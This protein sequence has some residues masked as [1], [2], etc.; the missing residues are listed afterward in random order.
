MLLVRNKKT[1]EVL[2]L[3]DDFELMDMPE[4]AIITLKDY[5]LSGLVQYESIDP[6]TT[7]ELSNNK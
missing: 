7:K 6:I 4:A 2:L 1:K 5:S 3:S